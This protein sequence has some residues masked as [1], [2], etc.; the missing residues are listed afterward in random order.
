V[1]VA[2]WSSNFYPN[3]NRLGWFAEQWTADPP[4]RSLA[5]R[6]WMGLLAGVPDVAIVHARAVSFLEVKT[7]GA[8]PSAAQADLMQQLD[9][10]GARCAVVRAPSRM[11][12]RRWLA[13]GSSPAT[14]GSGWLHNG[15]NSVPYRVSFEG[16]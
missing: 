11:L 10:S 5:K 16:N 7:P 15:A 14:R 12:R 3:T 13:G 6:R 9:S 1:S 8:K 4:D 2:G